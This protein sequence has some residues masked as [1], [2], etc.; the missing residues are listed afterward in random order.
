VRA[1]F[2][3]LAAAMLLIG[4]PPAW[5][6]SSGAHP[7]SRQ[8]L[9]GQAA[10]SRVG[11]QGRLAAKFA[12]RTAPRVAVGFRGIR[13]SSGSGSVIGGVTKA[14]SGTGGGGMGFP[15]PL[16]LIAMLAGAILLGAWRLKGREGAG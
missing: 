10:L 5:A 6:A 15:M 9:A 8:A 14:L 13:R 12:A 7:Y 11:P 1:A 16:L 4:A 3:V 2:A